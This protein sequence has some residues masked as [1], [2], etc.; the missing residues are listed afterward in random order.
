MERIAWASVPENPRPCQRRIIPEPQAKVQIK[1]K[2][3]QIQD[4][5]QVTAHEWVVAQ[6]F[7]QQE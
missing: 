2:L 6:I 7:Q 3:V 4:S 5:F 1:T